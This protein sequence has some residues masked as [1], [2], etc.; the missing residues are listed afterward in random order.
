V[1]NARAQSSC[2]K[3]FDEGRLWKSLD[4]AAV[5]A[6]LQGAFQNITQLMDCVGCVP[7][8]AFLSLPYPSPPSL[9]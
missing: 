8:A 1:R 2:P 4:A 6:Q 7:L 9:P 3:P 5:K